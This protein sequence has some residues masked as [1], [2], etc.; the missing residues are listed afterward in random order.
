MA[1]NREKAEQTRDS[2]LDAAAVVFLREGVSRATLEQIARQAGVTRGALYYH[3]K[4]KSQIL[5]SLLAQATL[6]HEELIA[7]AFAGDVDQP[8]RLIEQ[9]CRVVLQAL[10]RDERRQ[11]IYAILSLRCEAVGETAEVARHMSAMTE[12]MNARLLHMLRLCAAKGE[13]APRWTP[14]AAVWAIHCTMVGLFLEWL[15]GGRRF[16]LAEVGRM[17][18]GSV[19]AGLR[20]DARLPD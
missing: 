18:I 16:D 5:A 17:T 10:A 12:E 7:P 2:L 13:L 3:F 9:G 19:I 15:R 14:E 4:D 1:T 20:P 11:R 6:P 8:L